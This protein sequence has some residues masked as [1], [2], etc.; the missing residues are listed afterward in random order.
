MGKDLKEMKVK[1]KKILGNKAFWA[2]GTASAAAQSRDTLDKF[3]HLA[4]RSLCVERWGS[5]GS[6]GQVLGAL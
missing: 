6:G 1:P 2:K 4:K 5:R 3:D